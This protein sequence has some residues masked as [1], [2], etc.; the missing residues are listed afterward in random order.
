MSEHQDHSL[1]LSEQQD[2]VLNSRYG[3]SLKRM[4]ARYPEGVPDPIAARSLGMS[5]E[6]Y[7]QTREQAKAKLAEEMDG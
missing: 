1:S 5:E 7:V 2:F 3:N 4:A 6:A